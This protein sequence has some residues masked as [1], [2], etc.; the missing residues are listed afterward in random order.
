MKRHLRA[1]S[2]A[3]RIGRPPELTLDS[4]KG[5]SLVV[6][7]LMLIGVMLLGLSASQIAL[8]GE[9][10]SRND[11]DRQI[12]F[13]AAEAALLDAELDIENSPDPARSR[14]K[15]FSKEHGH[16]FIAGCGSGASNPYLGLCARAAEG[17]VPAWIA[18][19]FLNHSK[20]S[21]SV[22]FGT[23]TGQ[24]F[25]TGQGSL[26]AGPPRYILELIP[27]NRP[28][29]SAELSDRTHLYRVTAIGFGMRDATRVVLQTFYRKE[30]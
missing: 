7:L 30:E 1:A 6:S 20:A 2:G 11:R 15:L 16:A 22:P 23:F 29:E 24:N 9:K 12:A 14:S 17:A 13:Q 19:D 4:Q 25:P 8:Q 3:A 10:A 18:I 21:V 28:G 27:S 26:P 5:A